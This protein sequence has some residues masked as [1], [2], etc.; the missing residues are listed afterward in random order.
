MLV[1]LT[2]C[3]SLVAASM[4]T[5]GQW[6]CIFSVAYIFSINLLNVGNKMEIMIESLVHLLNI[7]YEIVRNFAVHL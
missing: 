3:M 6:L 7:V 1:Q 2:S 5:N 4:S